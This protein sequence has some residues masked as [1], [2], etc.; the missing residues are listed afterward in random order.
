MAKRKRYKSVSISPSKGGALMSRVSASE[1]GVANYLVKRDWRRDSDYEMRRE[2]YDYFGDFEG[3]ATGLQPFPA[4]SSSTD[5]VTLIHM[6]R[7]ETGKTQ[8]L[9]GT[10]TALYVFNALE[11]E[12]VLDPNSANNPYVSN[13]NVQGGV[14][15]CFAFL[16][17]QQIGSGFSANGRRWEAVNINGYT[18]LNNGV[19][20]PVYWKIGDQQVTPMTELRDLGVAHVGTIAAYNNILMIGD[21]REIPLS[22]HNTWMNGS[23]PYGQY[24]DGLSTDRYQYRLLW[25][26]INNPT[27]FGA[28]VGCTSTNGN[29]ALTLSFPSES[30]LSG[31]KVVV[32]GA[33]VNGGNLFTTISN[34]SGTTVTLADQASHSNSSA[35][36]QKQSS[37]GSITGYDDLEDDASGIL[38]MGELMGQLVIYKDTSSFLAKYTGTVSSPFSF[39]RL[40]LSPGKSLYYKNTLTIVDGKY[41]IYAGRSAFYRFDLQN[42][43]P[44]EVSVLDRCSDT[45]FDDSNT[46][47]GNTDQIFASNNSITKEVWFC[48]PS[49]SSDK[50]LCLDTRYGTVSTTS[51][52]I[53]SAL[54]V[55]RPTLNI[56]PVESEDW[57]VMGTSDGVVLLYGSVDRALPWWGGKDEIY[58]R[59]SSRTNTTDTEGYDSTLSSGLTDMGDQFN[60]KDLRSYLPALSSQQESLTNLGLEVRI[61]TAETQ[62]GTEISGA[63]HVIDEPNE[64]LVS[65]FLRAHNFRDELKVTGKDNPVRVA[66]RTYEVS[67]IGSRSAIRRDD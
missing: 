44:I 57:F 36:I 43:Q 37:I 32:I 4:G 28:V 65:L 6:V 42:R 40:P 48:F 39:T 52:N 31:D 58:Y 20:L 26:S 15:P 16:E 13:V 46:N 25:S 27:E 54:T 21:V 12:Y 51:I 38:K 7:S 59:R 64:A 24:P 45:F 10:A 19:D 66:S 61:Y 50:A 30:F 53:T 29:N 2:G 56:V 8:V 18:I 17:W 67:R 47:I 35:L 9:A 33:G 3:L 34:I 23:T 1:A 41:H 60:E 55:K 49:S 14:E 62:T 5:P 22:D 11:Y 63:H